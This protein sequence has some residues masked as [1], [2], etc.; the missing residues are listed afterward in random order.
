MI[1][2]KKYYAFVS[3][4]SKRERTILYI[5][6]GVVSLI[7]LDRL[8]IDP[9]LSKMRALDDQ[10]RQEMAL[11]KSDLHILAQKERVAQESQKYEAYSIPD[12]TTEEI[13]TMLLKEIGN[14]A[15][16]TSVYLI[17]IK[18]TGIK[19]GEVYRQYLINLSC[20]AQMEQIVSFMY[21]IEDSSSLMK[22]EKYNISPK[23]EDSSIARCSMVISKTAIP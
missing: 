8:I 14:L 22:I 19:E 10:T 12:L 21:G 18:P 23:T 20:E 4:L 17:D 6:V 16:K 2:F 3:H 15:S 5:A 7:I 9:V 1:D 11:I 13:T